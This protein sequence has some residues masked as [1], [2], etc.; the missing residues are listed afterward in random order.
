MP[1]RD[2]VRAHVVTVVILN[3]LIVHVTYLLIGPGY[4]YSSIVA[5]DTLRWHVI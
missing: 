3:T 4:C 1:V 5:L 2:H